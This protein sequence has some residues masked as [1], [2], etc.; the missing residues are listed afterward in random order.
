MSELSGIGA[1]LGSGT[2]HGQARVI[3]SISELDTMQ[4]GEVLVVPSTSVDYVAAMKKAV[5]IVT[6]VGGLTCHAAIVSRELGKPCVV[7][8]HTATKVF[9]TGDPLEV[10]ARHGIVRL[11][12]K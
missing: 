3:G 6:E 11:V 1:S 8:T 5:A 12:K 10:D 9:H 4:E 2:V 7:N